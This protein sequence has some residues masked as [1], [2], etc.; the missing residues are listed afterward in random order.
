MRKR[1]KKNAKLKNANEWPK[2]LSNAE[3]KNANQLTVF[4]NAELK[5]AIHQFFVKFENKNCEVLSKSWENLHLMML[6]LA[7]TNYTS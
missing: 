1:E 3:L 4:G 5:I 2:N 6:I 7:C